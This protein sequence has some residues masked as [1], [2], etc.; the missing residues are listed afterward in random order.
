MRDMVPT[1]W[2]LAEILLFLGLLSIYSYFIQSPGPNGLSRL[3][4][5]LSVAERGTM[6]IDAY[7]SNTVDKGYF[8]GHYYSDKPI[9]ISMFSLPAY[10]IIR[11]A[12]VDLG[13]W[14]LNLQMIVY[15]LNLVVVAVP[16]AL[17]GVLVYR[18]TWHMGVAR[19]P[20]LVGA[21]AFGLGTLVFP[22]AVLYF[23]HATSAF[24][25]FAAF[26]ALFVATRRQ[27]SGRWVALAGALVGA[28]VITEYPLV[29]VGAVL[30]VYLLVR[31]RTWRNLALYVLGG[32][33]FAL[34]LGLYN[35]VNFD[36][37]FSLSYEHVY[38]QQ[39]A[40]MHQGIFG[41]TAPSGAV[42]M[43]LLFSGKGLLTYSPFLILAPLGA[44]AL[45]RQPRWRPEALVLT[46]VVVLFLTYNSAY[47]LPFGGWTPGP[48][49]LVPMLPFAGV[50]VG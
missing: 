5:V 45:L 43:D 6:T 21:V 36:S 41:L 28:A 18:M 13:L 17:L 32:L 24:F 49:F 26:Y 19:L 12:F 33:P 40:G 16:S 22:F 46:A 3:D 35:Y 20:A 2:A 39:F 48:R 27:D 23:G 15:L 11:S 37:P 34:V 8:A 47:F 31:L 1:R 14:P 9:G 4:L 7:Q 10:L 25:G 30:L 29:I 38:L 50:A 42:V 44:F